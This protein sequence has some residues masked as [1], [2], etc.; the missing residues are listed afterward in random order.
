MHDQGETSLFSNH[1][2]QVYHSD[3]FQPEFC[4][5]GHSIRILISLI[6]YL[7]TCLNGD[8]GDQLWPQRSGYWW[9]RRPRLVL[10][11]GVSPITV[12]Q[13]VGMPASEFEEKQLKLCLDGIVVS[14]W[15]ILTISS[16]I[17]C[18]CR[19]ELIAF[20]KT[21]ERDETVLVRS[22]FIQRNS[23]RNDLYN[24]EKYWWKCSG[25]TKGSFIRRR[26]NLLQLRRVVSFVKSCVVETSDS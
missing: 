26:V 1:Y 16:M 24:E 18:W 6:F 13:V 23:V 21:I 2:H 7:Q 3:T 19:I 22:S 14:S 15:D 8:V 10:L 25:G 4:K 5:L 20:P 17:L 12:L 9:S 11:R